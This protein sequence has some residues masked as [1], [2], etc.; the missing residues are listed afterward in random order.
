M[1][2]KVRYTVEDRIGVVVID[3]PPVNALG[4]E[5]LD[6]LDKILDTAAGDD[7]KVILITGN[8]MFFSA[9]A[10]IKEIQ[11][12]SSAAQALEKIKKGQAVLN[13]IENFKK[14]V[15]AAING[16]CLGGGMELAMACHIRIA[17]DMT[18][19]GQPEI[20]LGAI[21][22]FGGTQR[23]TRLVGSARAAE[24]ILTGDQVTAKDALA[25]GLVNKIT[26]P[27]TLIK[28]A[29]SLCKKLAAMGSEAM[30]EA[31]SLITNAPDMTIAEG[32]QKE[33]EAFSKLV[34]TGDMKE[35]L[36]AFREKRRPKFK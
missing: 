4:E 3:N 29:K 9:G 1:P 24:I 31:L 15:I 16:L 26:P 8:G 22:G 32:L 10:D 25:M 11:N 33:A 14:P 2:D 30:A 36:K 27:E 7:S 12:F 21:P 28:H 20:T 6:A 19:L 18:K 5:V 17:S 13:K 23:L 34:E 35:G